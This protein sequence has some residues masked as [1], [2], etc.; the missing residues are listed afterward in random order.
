[1]APETQWLAE[2]AH[3]LP[4]TTV[5]II[6]AIVSFAQKTLVLAKGASTTVTVIADSALSDDL[7]LVLELSGGTL[8]KDDFSNL[9]HGIILAR[10]QTST[11]FE[12]NVLQDLQ[13]EMTENTTLTLSLDPSKPAIA[14]LSINN[15]LL[16]SVPV[17]DTPVL[18]IVA[19]G[20]RTIHEGSSTAF[21]VLASSTPISDIQIIPL[22]DHQ[23]D[24]I[25]EPVTIATKHLSLIHI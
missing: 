1:M 17:N 10:E 8:T 15:R 21:T 5:E 11:S 20:I 14:E 22:F 4:A 23:D 18:S 24:V 16:I 7:S 19:E 6:P 2:G 3:R 13:A 25:I 12:L 9:K